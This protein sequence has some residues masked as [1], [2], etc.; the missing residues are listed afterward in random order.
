MLAKQTFGIQIAQSIAQTMASIRSN[1]LHRHLIWPGAF[2]YET[3]PTKHQ[4]NYYYFHSNQVHRAL[5]D[6]V[7]D[8]I[9]EI[10]SE[11]EYFFDFRS[12]Q[13]FK[14]VINEWRVYKWQQALFGTQKD[15]LR[16]GYV[17]II[18]NCNQ[19]TILP[20][21]TNGCRFLSYASAMRTACTVSSFCNVFIMFF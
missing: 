15:C 3:F 1:N 14:C 2:F 7:L 12:I 16:F 17:Y 21:L 19:L 4:T 8:V 20:S 9:N 18:Q 11:Y 6:V 5:P 10:R 13:S